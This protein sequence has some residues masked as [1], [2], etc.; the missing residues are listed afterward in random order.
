MHG[1]SVYEYQLKEEPTAGAVISEVQ[2]LAL[3]DGKLC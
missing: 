1:Y 2:I 3:E